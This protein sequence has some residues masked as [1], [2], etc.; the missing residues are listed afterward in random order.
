VPMSTARR[1]PRAV[2]RYLKDHAHRPVTRIQCE[3]RF[4]PAGIAVAEHLFTTFR[5]ILREMFG[6]QAPRVDVEV[7]DE[8]GQLTLVIEAPESQVPTVQ[9]ALATFT[10]T[11]KG[12]YSLERFVSDEEV[13]DR[14]Q[15]QILSLWAYIRAQL[16]LPAVGPGSSQAPSPPP[17]GGDSVPME[18][19]AMAMQAVQT[20]LERPTVQKNYYQQGASVGNDQ[21]LKIG[22]G[23]KRSNLAIHSPGAILK[24]ENG[25]K[26]EEL[27]KAMEAAAERDQQVTKAQYAEIVAQLGLLRG[28]L[29]K[30]KP[31]ASVVEKAV[32]YLGGIASITSL[33]WQ[34]R[35]AFGLP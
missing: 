6:R 28:E 31:D 24:I 9:H 21:S 34:A 22:R 25:P 29:A 20:A 7:D 12:E 30:P 17:R 35:T 11:V 5:G 16:G 32:N 8:T 19:Y 2:V 15:R 4:E 27:L 14:V 13:R 10:A 3:A 1:G 33:A 26:I 23:V 18:A